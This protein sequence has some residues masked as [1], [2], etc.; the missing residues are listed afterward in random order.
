MRLRY[1]YTAFINQD[2]ILVWWATSNRT[3]NSK[4]KVYKVRWTINKFPRGPK[5][6]SS[7]LV[8][9]VQFS[10]HNALVRGDLVI[11]EDWWGG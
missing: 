5:Y 8:S 10:W 4:L 6:C 2:I 1:W 11:Q 9:L 7:L 3:K